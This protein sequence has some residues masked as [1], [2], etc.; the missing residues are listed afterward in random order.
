MADPL[1][2][3]TARLIPQTVFAGPTLTFDFPG[4]QIGIAEYPEGPT[5]CTVFLFPDGVA[6]AIDA[7]GGSVGKTGDYEWNHAICLAGGSLFGLEA[8]TGV[9]AELFARRNYGIDNFGLV[10]GA[11]IFDF[12]RR[13]TRIYPDK[14]LGRAAA[15]VAQSG[16]FPLGPR[17]AGRSAGCGGVFDRARS[18]SSGQGGAFQQVGPTKVGVF[19]VVNALGVVVD[20]E[21]QVVRGNLDRGTGIR[22][23]PL[24]D[25][26]ELLARQAPTASPE[27]N[28]TLTVLV[29]NQKLSR[30]ALQQLG[31]QVH[32]SMARA[33]TPFH[34]IHD[35]D[36]L[37]AVTTN[38][39]EN[40]A[41][42]E[43]ALGM[44]ASELAWDAVLRCF[45]GSPAP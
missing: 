25:L 35:G 38:T 33:I 26:H 2:N 1:S 39:V 6:T 13:D 21:G 36:V 45:E 29:T 27:G 31:R 24:V 34:T 10:S 42:S 16:V 14:A 28:T 23:H 41:L 11:I 15:Q 43:T 18:E 9:T 44:L 5:G 7:R 22:R 37:Y 17:G 40:S 20:R 8:A 32:S 3:D 4:M 19:T 12:G 30:H